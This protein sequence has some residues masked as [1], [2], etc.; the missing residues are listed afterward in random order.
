ME[1]GVR[2]EIGISRGDETDGRVVAEFF[3]GVEDEA[4]GEG[5]RDTGEMSTAKEEGDT[6]KIGIG[7]NTDSVVFG[8]V[9]GSVGVVVRVVRLVSDIGVSVV[10]EVVAVVASVV[11]VL[12]GGEVKSE[13]LPMDPESEAEEGT[14]SSEERLRSGGSASI[15]DPSLL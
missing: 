5:E 15:M 11:Y 3:G 1:R 9:I 6:G 10:G 7:V 4:E 2:G 8:V 14:S 13:D 12:R